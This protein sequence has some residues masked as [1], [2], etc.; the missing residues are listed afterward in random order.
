M[1]TQNGQQVGAVGLF[2]IDPNTKLDRFENSGVIPRGQATEILDFGNNGVVQGF[3][4]EANVNPVME[5]N[6]LIAV[7]RA[8][9]A[10]ELHDHQFR[11][12]H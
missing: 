9:D 12:H 6:R 3:V 5:M 10:R 4:E 8:F 1:I 2:S 11:H 7:S